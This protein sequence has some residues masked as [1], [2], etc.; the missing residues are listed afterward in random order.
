MLAWANVAVSIVKL[1]VLIVTALEKHKLI[2]AAQ[3]ELAFDVITDMRRQADLAKEAAIQSR[4]D[5]AA[6]GLRNDDGHRRD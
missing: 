4:A 6:G 5:S 1:A 3:K 2:T